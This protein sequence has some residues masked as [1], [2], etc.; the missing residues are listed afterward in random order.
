MAFNFILP[1]EVDISGNEAN[2][3]PNSNTVINPSLIKMS[4]L[5]PT[6]P[7]LDFK[8]IYNFQ[9]IQFTKASDESKVYGTYDYSAI[10]Y[11]DEA[12]LTKSSLSGTGLNFFEVVEDASKLSS[13]LSQSGLTLYNPE[14]H[15][16]DKPFHLFRKN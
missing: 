14:V 8:G 9:Q 6:I 3:F 16:F 10:T 5:D 2:G 7:E 15:K 4:Y 13:T 11:N 1:C 12:G